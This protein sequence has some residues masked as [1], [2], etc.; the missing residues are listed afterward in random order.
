MNDFRWRHF[1]GD[2]ILHCVR[3]YCKC[4]ISYRDLEEM[5]EERGIN[6]DHTILYRLEHDDFRL[7]HTLN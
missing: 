6:V 5:K 7:T 1:A 4:G 3:W 2:I